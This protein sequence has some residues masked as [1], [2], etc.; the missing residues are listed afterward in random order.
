MENYTGAVI[1]GDC[2]NSVC[3]RCYPELPQN[4]KRI[5]RF[6]GDLERILIEGKT[7]K[8]ILEFFKESH[9]FCEGIDR[10]YKE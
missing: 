3:C 7:F 10:K 2:G 6:L 9:L 8:E 4:K 5:Q 1:Q